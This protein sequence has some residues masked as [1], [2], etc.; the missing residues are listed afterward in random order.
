MASKITKFFAPLPSKASVVASKD[1][2]SNKRKASGS[3]AAKP[4]DVIEIESPG[5]K[6][7]VRSPSCWR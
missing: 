6:Q 7:Q 4:V 1:T 3:D 5:D 2:A